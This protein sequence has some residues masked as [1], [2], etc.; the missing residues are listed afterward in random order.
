MAQY[1]V[2]HQARVQRME[3]RLERLAG[4]HLAGNGYHGIGV[5][6]CIRMGRDAAARLART[7]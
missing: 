1:T 4:L 6:D 2:G 3:A 7:A 5:P